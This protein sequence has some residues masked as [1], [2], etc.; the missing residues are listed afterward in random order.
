MKKIFYQ[1]VVIATLTL[2]ACASSTGVSTSQP[3]FTQTAVLTAPST[4]SP[5]STATDAVAALAPTATIARV[6]SSSAS[7]SSLRSVLGDDFTSITFVNWSGRAVNVYW[8]N[9]EGMEEFYFE[10][11]PGESGKQETY[12]THPWCVRD[13]ASNA[14]LLAIVATEDEQV[15]T[16]LREIQWQET[17]SIPEAS[18]GP[19]DTFRGQQLI[20]NNGRVYIFGGGLSAGDERLTRVLFSAIQPDGSLAEWQETTPLPGKYYD[21]VVVKAGNYV[22]L[23]TGA[24]GVEKVYV[25]PFNSDG[26]VGAWKETTVLS[27]SRQTFAAVSDGN[28]IYTAGGNSG[29]IQNVVQYTSVNADGSLAPWAH[30][31]PLPEAVQEH[32]MIAYDGYLYVIGGKQANDEW[33][34]TVYFSTIKPDG[35]LVDWKTTTPLPQNIRGVATFESDGYVYLLSG[36]A[37][38]YTRILESHALDEWQRTTALPAVRNGLWVGAN[39]GHVYAVGGSDSAGQQSTV[40]HASLESIFAYPDCTS[41]WTRLKADSYAEVSQDNPSPNRVRDAPHTG[42]KIIQ[43]L[44]PGEIVRVVE[45]P[46]CENGLVFWKVENALI[47]GG[48]GW[49]AEGDGKETSFFL[50]PYTP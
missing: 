25:A 13:K 40:Y 30:T 7:C 31:T 23:L 24:A 27:P 46:V 2:S 8:V 50:E 35:T 39:N 32:T 12:A 41:G 49:T 33:T 42:A 1:L 15:A 43:Q 38:Y 18:A 29:G 19:L 6:A 37:S 9:Y 48:V 26:S 45:G 14:A 44:Y 34:N 22:Y 47:P 17:V 16:V 20:V 21:P 4:T 3:S 28:F 11:Q 5:A 36:E 10:L